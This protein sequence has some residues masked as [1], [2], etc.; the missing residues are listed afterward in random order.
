MFVRS[1]ASFARRLKRYEY[2]TSITSNT[3]LSTDVK[4]PKELIE[5]M[6]EIEERLNSF[7]NKEN[8]TNVL[9]TNEPSPKKHKPNT[10]TSDQSIGFT[11]DLT[12]DTDVS[13]IVNIIN[14]SGYNMNVRHE[15]SPATTIPNPIKPIDAGSNPSSSDSSSETSPVS[16]PFG[17]SGANLS[18][19]KRKLSELTTS[20]PSKFNTP[21]FD[22]TSGRIKWPECEECGKPKDP[23]KQ[24]HC[25][26]FGQYKCNKC[27]HTWASAYAW[28]GP[29]SFHKR[30]FD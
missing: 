3:N 26:F 21:F 17:F 25:R 1:S 24:H 28:K 8:N 20:S 5:V 18:P 2:L 23:K 14:K 4:I 30:K 11:I 27:G 19:L 12:G 15:T 22:E 10:S 9:T 29:Y 13:T 7:E 16:S 6:K